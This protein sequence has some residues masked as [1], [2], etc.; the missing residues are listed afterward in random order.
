MS[1]IAPLSPDD[2]NLGA[3]YTAQEVADFLVRWAVKTNT[4]RIL[5]PSF[6]GGVFL[7]AACRQLAQFHGNPAQSVLG[8]ELDSAAHGQVCLALQH[9]YGVPGSQLTRADFFSL[10]PGSISVDAVVGNPPFIRYQ[11][12]S[13][14]CRQRAIQVAASGGV[15]LSELSSSWAPFVVH[16]TSMLR[17]GGRLGFVLPAEIMHA[18]YARPILE[19]LNRT[20]ANI[21][22]VTFRRRL[23]PELSQ[24]TLLLLADAKTCNASARVRLRQLNDSHD[25]VKIPIGTGR[26]VAKRSL[27]MA[28]VVNGTDRFAKQLLPKG[29]RDLYDSLAQHPR[30]ARLDQLADV[31]IGY[32]TGGNDFFHLGKE[33]A[34]KWEI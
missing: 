11:R 15:R 17:F 20:F 10:E 6:G 26:P 2:K 22:F 23:F 33:D 9:E 31:G 8:V 29:V 24:D 3:Y 5:D 34:E 25:L 13:G 1:I 30:V 27:R 21:S 7:H 32:V 28:S 12:F 16:S 4:D 18:A 19:F 14:A